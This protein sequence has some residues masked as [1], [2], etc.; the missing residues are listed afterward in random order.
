MAYNQA[1]LNNVYNYYL[2]TY[3]PRSSSRYDSHKRSELRSIYNSII[4]LNKDA[5]L[6]KMD[7][8]R[9]CKNFAIGI[10][11]DARELHNTIASLGGLDEEKI[12]NKK[13]A[14]S[15]NEDLAM[16]SFIGDIQEAEATPSYEI[17]VRSLATGQVNIGAYLPNVRISLPTDTYSFDVNINDLNYEFQYNIREGETN[18]DIQQRLAKLISSAGIGLNADVIEDGKGNTALRL[19]SLAEGSKNNGSPL[20]LVSD[21]HTSKRSGTVA[22]LGLDHLA[23][24]ASDA[25]FVVN[26]EKRTSSS[27]TFVLDNLYHITLRGISSSQ[28]DTTTVGLKTDVESLTE[29]VEVLVNSYNQFINHTASHKDEFSGSRRLLGQMNGISRLY[30]RDL[31]S[32]GLNFQEDGTITLDKKEFQDTAMTNNTNRS[33]SAV[34]DFANS[35]VRKMDQISLNPMDY[36]D[37]TIVAYKNPG[38]NYAVPYITSAFSGMLFNSYC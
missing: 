7:T 29:N 30:R 22:C 35:L 38:K 33:F 37:K 34:R 6:Y 8:S 16:V 3:A 11:E 10:K 27:N 25:E 14:Y 31:H 4:K 24:P 19:S 18:K 12:L 21:S 32:L 15:S 36:A 28:Q 13:T 23:R 9:Q 26:G 5:P 20:F 2:S 1:I 17:E